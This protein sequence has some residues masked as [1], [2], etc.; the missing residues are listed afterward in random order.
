MR[1]DSH[2]K[3]GQ[4]HEQ[5]RGT[6]SFVVIGLLSSAILTSAVSP[7]LY[8]KYFIDQAYSV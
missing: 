6:K 8:N 7:K 1:Q 5:E 2:L 3:Y 4:L